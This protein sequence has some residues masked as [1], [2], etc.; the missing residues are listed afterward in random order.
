MMPQVIKMAYEVKVTRQGQ[1]T[2]PKPLREK[3]DIAEG[4][5][6][7][8]IDVGDHVAVLPVPKDPLTVLKGLRIE[9]K[10]TIYD[11]RKEALRTAQRLVEE[12]F[13][14]G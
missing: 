1:T 7:L 6:I 14:R 8:Y 9:E 2:I 13:K 12:K 11:I 3:Y 5:T 4:D 10:G